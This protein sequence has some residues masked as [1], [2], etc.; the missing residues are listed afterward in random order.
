VL[1]PSTVSI[2]GRWNWWPS[3]MSRLPRDGQHGVADQ[4][5][6]DRAGPTPASDGSGAPSAAPDQDGGTTGAE[7]LG[8]GEGGAHT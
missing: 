8:A 2:L 7:S 5:T 3:A 4:P 1:V 6:L